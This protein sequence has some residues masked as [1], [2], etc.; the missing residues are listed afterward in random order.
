MQLKE[1]IITYFTRYPELRVLFF[2]DPMGDSLDEIAQLEPVGYIIVYFANNA[3][4]LKLKFHNEWLNEK[5]FLYLPCKRPENQEEYLRFPLLDLLVANR[6]LRLDDVGEFMDE[7]NLKSHHR[8]LVQNYIGEL[9]YASVQRV[10]MPVLNAANFEEKALQKA[11]VS[12]F[13]RFT[14]PESTELLLAKILTLGLKGEEAEL[15]RFR[16]KI[17]ENK[18]QETLDLWAKDFFDEKLGEISEDRLKHLA[19]RLKYNA[20]TAGMEPDEKDPYSP[21]KI[22]DSF[23]LN[24]LLAIKDQALYNTSLR[25]KFTGVLEK[26][27]RQ[28]REP[29]LVE[30][31]G[32]HGSFACLNKALVVELQAA[33][34]VKM[35]TDPIAELPLLERIFGWDGLEGNLLHVNNFL[36]H[37]IQAIQQ[38]KQVTNWVLDQPEEYIEQYTSVWYRID[39]SY[40]KAVL[41]YNLADFS[42]DIH[43]ELYKNTKDTIERAYHSFINK[44]NR[45]WLKCLAVKKFDYD[46]LNIPLQYNFYRTEIEPLDQK[47]AVIIS[48]ALRYEVAAELLKEIHKDSRSE[49]R[50]GYCLASI[51]STT[52]VG[53]TNLLP[54]KSFKVEGGKI[55]VDGI[56]SDSEN[57]EQVLQQAKPDSRVISSSRLVELSQADAREVFKSQVVYVYHDVIDSIGHKRASEKQTFGSIETA[58]FPELARLIKYLHSSM[59]VSKVLVTADHGFIYN[60]QKIEEKDFEPSI[61][62]DSNIGSLKNRYGI[63]EKEHKPESGYCIPFNKTNKIKYDGYVIIPDGV[64]RYHRQGAGTRFVHGG[65]S[66][67]ELVV[68]VI[69]SSRRRADISRKVNPVLLTSK[70]LVV[71]NTLRIQLLQENPVSNAE[72]ERTILVGL[73]DGNDQV[74]NI[75]EVLMK[76]TSEQPSKRMFSVTLVLLP[77]QANKSRFTLRIFDS[78]DP[79]NRLIEKDAENSTLYGRDF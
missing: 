12:S 47:V 58:A 36:F 43:V 22:H 33:V 45:E 9:K 28:V 68:P 18:L 1:K 76:E 53:M 60:D 55:T 56:Q 37:T 38:I 63:L 46:A 5:V 4:T 54:G 30:I 26:L 31:Y 75:E 77:G 61:P 8:S 17:T 79:L 44:T 6:E 64:N 49:A 35:V 70:L 40:R 71:S 23:R 2:F 72:K 16:K 14:K 34:L 21:L 41:A 32:V 10:I 42:A 24:N 65:G 69:E 27:G 50:I 73:Y 15:T 7:F 29:K 39:T 20:I 52:S 57:R 78:E 13:L 59:N 48:D 25:E 74:S 11:L 62:G 66:L 19:A 3:F 67:Q 51:P